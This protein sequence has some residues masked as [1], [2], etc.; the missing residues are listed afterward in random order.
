VQLTTGVMSEIER[1]S[2]IGKAQAKIDMGGVS[3]LSTNK[4]PLHLEIKASVPDLRAQYARW[5]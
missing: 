5:S 4:S 2:A 3:L 1:K